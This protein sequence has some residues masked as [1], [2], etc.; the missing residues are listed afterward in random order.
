MLSENQ[1]RSETQISRWTTSQTQS[2]AAIS[3]AAAR[4]SRPD[5]WSLLVLVGF[6]TSLH[7]RYTTMMIQVCVSTLIPR[8]VNKQSL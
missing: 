4:T 6:N 1:S 3:S 7:S 2:P 8:L 5:F